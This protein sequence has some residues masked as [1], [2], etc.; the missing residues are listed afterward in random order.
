VA[1]LAGAWSLRIGDSS[2]RNIMSIMSIMSITGAGTFSVAQCPPLLAI[3]RGLS[4]A[5][6]AANESNR[7]LVRREHLRPHQPDQRYDHSRG[8]RS[9][10]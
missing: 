6:A 1:K 2:S 5:E 3:G 8:N 7:R 9:P 4:V 10:G